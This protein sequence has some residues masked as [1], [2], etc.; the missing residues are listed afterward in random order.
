MG[1]LPVGHASRPAEPT[2]GQRGPE[3]RFRW[4]M[5]RS[6]TPCPRSDER[7]TSRGLPATRRRPR[8]PGRAEI[9]TALALGVVALLTVPTAA[10]TTPAPADRWA[11]QGYGTWLVVYSNY[12]MLELEKYLGP[13][14]YKGDGIAVVL[15]YHGL[16]AFNAEGRSLHTAFPNATLRGYTSLDGASGKAGGLSGVIK[17]ISSVYTQLSADYEVNGPV[18]FNPNW[19]ATQHYFQNFSSIVHKSG[20][21]AIAYPSGRG[22]FGDYSKMWNYGKIAGLTDGQTIE[23]QGF[24]HGGNWKAAVGH[25]W[26]E[27]NATKESTRTLSLQISIGKVANSCS[28]WAAIHAAKY[29]RQAAHGNIFWW[30]GPGNLAELIQILKIVQS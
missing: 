3:E 14:L 8:R 5:M 10:A 13:F 24:C 28:E 20:R 23:T 17:N 15:H 26:A 9:A 4:V 21:I 7:R 19:T 12:E 29:W 25:I 1:P 27:Y 16:S 2:P 6:L 30:W 11:G 22:V 18:E